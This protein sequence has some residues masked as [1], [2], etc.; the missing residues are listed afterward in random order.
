VSLDDV[1]A[2]PVNLVASGV[3]IYYGIAVGKHS[4]G[5]TAVIQVS[6]GAALSFGGGNL[7]EFGLSGGAITVF[8]S[9]GSGTADISVFIVY[10]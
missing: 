9:A 2:T 7:W 5:G 3:S 10:I 6:V 1:G 8:R 4:G